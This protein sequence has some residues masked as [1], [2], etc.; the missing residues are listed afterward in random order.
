MSNVMRR[1]LVVAAGGGLLAAPFISARPASAAEFTLKYANNVSAVHPL[2]VWVSKAADRVRE[3]TGGR[4]DIKIFP[5]SQLG[6]DQDMF[7]Q[8]RAG[9]IQFYTM[10]G[11]LLSTL[12]PLAAINGVG[13]AFPDHDSVWKAMDGDL[14]AMVRNNVE[15]ANIVI[16]DKIWNGGFRQITSSSKPINTPADLRAF[17]IRVPV[18]PLW[19]SLFEK[20]G[21]S[22][23]SI[24]F[25][26]VY[27]ALQTHVVDGQE[28]ALVGIEAAKL[29]E[30]QK[31]CSLTNHMWDGFWFLGNKAAWGKLPPDLQSKVA[32]IINGSA[33]EQRADV[34]RLNNS[35]QETLSRQ[36]MTFNTPDGAPFR[37]TL[38]KSGFYRDWQKRF[39]GDA[40]DLLEKSG[41]KFG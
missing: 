2:T 17:K 16:F 38:V 21:S 39:G 23:A 7:N 13:F 3:Q 28:N 31:Y 1:Q 5:N 22:P 37:E 34:I 25:G 19:T 36:G 18:S 8:L 40:W 33:L 15:K 6:S 27:S 35:L 10:S 32:D 14:G 20:L 29:Y 26:E 24:N 4:V 30:V 41:G 12:V 9:A 11:V